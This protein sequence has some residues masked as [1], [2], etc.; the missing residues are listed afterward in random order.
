[1]TS[2]PPRGGECVEEGWSIHMS[3]AGTPALDFRYAHA[4]I[5]GR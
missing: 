4:P 3:V 2:A 1:M 5:R